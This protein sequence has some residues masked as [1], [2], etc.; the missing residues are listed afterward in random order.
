VAAAKEVVSGW[1]VV[2]AASL[3]PVVAAKEGR[4]GQ[5]MVKVVAKE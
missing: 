2:G 3:L 4:R 1:S 5:S